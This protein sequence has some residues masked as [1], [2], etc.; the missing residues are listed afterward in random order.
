MA[1]ITTQFTW[2]LVG[3]VSWGSPW[4]SDTTDRPCLVRQV[5][6]GGR[7]ARFVA[8]FDKGLLERVGAGGG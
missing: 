8:S 2:S 6:P 7:R 5:N 3:S 1:K 4:H